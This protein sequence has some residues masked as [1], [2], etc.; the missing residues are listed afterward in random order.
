MG[1]LVSSMYVD[2]LA[3]KSA[4]G[5]G[6]INWRTNTFRSLRGRGHTLLRL[7][8]AVSV[9]GWW[10]IAFL[11]P[12]KGCA[13]GALPTSKQDDIIGPREPAGQRR[14]NSD[15]GEKTNNHDEEARIINKRR[16]PSASRGLDLAGS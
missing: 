9:I 11:C 15:A 2:T 13:Q 16:G 3:Q 4:L 1:R 14:G 6:G 7:L 12:Q 5:P 10:Q 8:C